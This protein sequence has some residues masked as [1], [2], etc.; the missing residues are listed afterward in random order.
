[1]YIDAGVVIVPERRDSNA[2]SLYLINYYS[3]KE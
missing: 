1:M 3:L 2:R